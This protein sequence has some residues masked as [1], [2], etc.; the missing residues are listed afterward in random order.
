[1][2]FRVHQE[3]LARSAPLECQVSLESREKRDSQDEMVSR[4][5]LDIL[6]DQVTNPTFLSS[7]SRP[8]FKMFYI[9][10]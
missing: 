1:L 3:H 4:V 9:Q 10:A 8:K 5:S 7:T 6:E 2:N